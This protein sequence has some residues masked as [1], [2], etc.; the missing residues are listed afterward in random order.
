[1]QDNVPYRLVIDCPAV[2]TPVRLAW[3][4]HSVL[5]QKLCKLHVNWLSDGDCGTIGLK[6]IALLAVECAR[7]GN[8]GIWCCYGNGSYQLKG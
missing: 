3:N 6:A 4:T 7:L 2:G 5:R 1:M 8:G